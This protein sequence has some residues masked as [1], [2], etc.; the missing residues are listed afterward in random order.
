MGTGSA[1]NTNIVLEELFD[2]NVVWLDHDATS[3]QRR[4]LMSTVPKNLGYSSMHLLTS[5]D[6]ITVTTVHHRILT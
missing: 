1:V 4:W 6:G 2:G 5:P 3:P